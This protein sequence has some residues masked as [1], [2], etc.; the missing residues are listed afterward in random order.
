MRFLF[1]ESCYVDFDRSPVRTV[2][3]MIRTE[4]KLD[5]NADYNFQLAAIVPVD[6][7]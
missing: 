4:R 6:A 7:K 2:A 3:W 1:D 5:I